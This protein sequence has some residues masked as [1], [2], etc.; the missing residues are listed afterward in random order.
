MGFTVIQIYM[1]LMSTISVTQT[2]H[3]ALAAAP[4]PSAVSVP[5]AAPL[6]LPKR[7]DTEASSDPTLISDE[8]EEGP[9][10][11]EGSSN[12]GSKSSSVATVTAVQVEQGPRKDAAVG[13]RGPFA[14]RHRDT[15]Q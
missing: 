15:D 1:A 9:R 14:I 11:C 7:S 13:I 12:P 6:V 3:V 2:S 4:E 8:P 5:S 10:D